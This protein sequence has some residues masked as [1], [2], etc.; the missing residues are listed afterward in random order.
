MPKPH[1]PTHHQ[2]FGIR[3]VKSV[4]CAAQ[5]IKMHINHAGR[6]CYELLIWSAGTL[7]MRTLAVILDNN[8]QL[9]K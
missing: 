4:Q 9:W 7:Y 3:A 6:V 1:I 2:S 8:L 5:C